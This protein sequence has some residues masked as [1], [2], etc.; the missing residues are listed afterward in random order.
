MPL[1]VKRLDEMPLAFREQLPFEDVA[2]VAAFPALSPTQ[3]H[4]FLV[5]RHYLDRDGKDGTMIEIGALTA[6]EAL[7]VSG[8]PRRGTTYP[9]RE[10]F[11]DQRSSPPA[12][13]RLHR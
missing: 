5:Y 3:N 7:A 2:I 13:I 11:R 4:L 8:P 6:Q 9:L 12:S 10:N 1:W